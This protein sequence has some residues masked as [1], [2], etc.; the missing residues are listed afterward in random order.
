LLATFTYV[1]TSSIRPSLHMLHFLISTPYFIAAN[2][3]TGRATFFGGVAICNCSQISF[4]RSPLCSWLKIPLCRIFTNP[5]G[6]IC[7]S[8]RCTRLYCQSQP[9][10]RPFFTNTLI[11]K[12]PKNSQV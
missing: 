8:K 3:A 12:T 7:C 11:H 10:Q 5:L 2:T 4:R 6:K 1:A 9:C